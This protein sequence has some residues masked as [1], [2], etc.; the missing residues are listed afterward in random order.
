[1][2]LRGQFHVAFGIIASLTI[3]LVAYGVFALGTTRNLV[4]QLYDE[5]LVAVSYARGASAALNEARGVMDRALLTGPLGTADIMSILD[6]KYA[7]IADDLWIVRERTHDTTLSRAL[8]ETNAAIA[9]WFKAG[10]M[11][12]SPPAGGVTHLPM[13]EAVERRSALAASRLDDLIE[14]ATA[15]GYAYRA[16]AAAEMRVSA[17]TLAGLA[18]GIVVLSGLF[19]L[20]FVQMLIAPIRAATQIAEDVAADRRTTIGATRRRDEI[21]RLLTSLASMQ[22]SLRARAIQAAA[23]VQDKERSA[24]ALQLIN[25]RFD[26]ALNNMAHGLL[27][28]DSEGRLAVANRRFCDL[29]QLDPRN[30]IPGTSLRHIVALIADAGDDADCDIDAQHDEHMQIVLSRLRRTTKRMPRHCR[31]CIPCEILAFALRW[32]I[33]APG[34]RRSPIC[35]VSHSIR[36]R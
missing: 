29:Y 17:F 30:V 12:L 3:L 14:L 36:S 25:G 2:S 16:R 4:F 8:G 31:R 20:S 24:E 35:G 32:M 19:A 1:M 5:P 11:I 22:A 23:L 6:R 9:D 28:W 33:S 15:D 27:M 21:G 10:A 26:T 13:R 34:I 18:G 7:E